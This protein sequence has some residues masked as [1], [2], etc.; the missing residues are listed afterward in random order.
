[1][2]QK[3]NL[4]HAV[5][6]AGIE[7]TTKSDKMKGPDIKGLEQ[8]ADW[9]V[10]YLKKEADIEGKKHMKAATGSDDELK[11]LAAWLKAQ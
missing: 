1:M 8:D 11:A 5:P 7:A 6:A 10:A 4:C 2:D 3:C 9:I